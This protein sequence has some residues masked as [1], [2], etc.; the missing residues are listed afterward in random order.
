[1]PVSYLHNPSPYLNNKALAAG[2]LSELDKSFSKKDRFDGPATGGLIVSYEFEDSLSRYTAD[3]VE[4]EIQWNKVRHF[5]RRLLRTTPNF[6]L[7]SRTSPFSATAAP[8]VSRRRTIQSPTPLRASTVFSRCTPTGGAKART[9]R[10]PR[11]T[12]STSTPA[13][14]GIRGARRVFTVAEDEERT[15]GRRAGCRTTRSR[16][17]PRGGRRRGRQRPST[18]NSSRLEIGRAH[19]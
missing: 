6:L 8:T 2:G 15:I 18:R 7:S 3:L 16:G 14:L 1:M 5:F 19:V 9:T 4:D 13:W 11:L 10:S 12:T 17:T